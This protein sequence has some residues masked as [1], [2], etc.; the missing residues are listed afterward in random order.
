V[1]VED[2]LP[3]P[4]KFP[5]LQP[6]ACECDAKMAISMGGRNPIYRTPGPRP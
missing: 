4:A 5:T 3:P 1:V 2:S 6:A